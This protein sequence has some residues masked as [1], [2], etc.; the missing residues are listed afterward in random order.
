MSLRVPPPPIKSP[1]KRPLASL[2]GDDYASGSDEEVPNSA[3]HGAPEVTVSAL[4][5]KKKR[6]RFAPTE[7]LTTIIYFDS[8]KP[9]DPDAVLNNDDA[10][11]DEAAY[12]NIGGTGDE[13]ED[14]GTDGILSA[15]L[16]AAERSRAE[17]V[18]SDGGWSLA[19]AH[20]NRTAPPPTTSVTPKSSFS[21][22]KAVTVTTTKR[23]VDITP[24]V[25][26]PQSGLWA[27]L[28]PPPIEPVSLPSI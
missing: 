4:S 1:A 7:M 25:N 17:V 5:T 28:A 3:V 24:S 13:D 12:N 18:V 23:L 20:K 22:A 15:V 21:F 10:S 14:E 2:L 9:I 8:A 26:L 16:A 27:Q 6:L 11:D 19:A